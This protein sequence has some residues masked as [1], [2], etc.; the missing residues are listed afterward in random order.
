MTHLS[1]FAAPALRD[2]NLI[3]TELV[4]GLNS[5][6]T[7]AFIGPNDI[8]LLQKKRREGTSDHWWNH[9]TEYHLGR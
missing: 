1:A 5:P 8:L 6:T 2:T 7:M 4:S 9:S 3:V